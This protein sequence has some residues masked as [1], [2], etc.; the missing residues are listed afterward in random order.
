[1]EKRLQQV[2]SD[3][4]QVL[5]EYGLMVG[6][7]NLKD[8]APVWH[9]YYYNPQTLNCFPVLKKIG[10]QSALPDRMADLVQGFDPDTPPA[11]ILEWAKKNG[12]LDE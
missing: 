2:M 8:H 1:M 10:P 5:E 7:P 3:T 9:L 4:N 11:A 12:V 6:N